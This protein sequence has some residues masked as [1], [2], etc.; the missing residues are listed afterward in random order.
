MPNS[1][2]PFGWQL[3]WRP[4]WWSVNCTKTKLVYSSTFRA[5]GTNTHTHTHTHKSHTQELDNHRAMQQLLE[6][7]AS[8]V[9]LERS[10]FVF[11]EWRCSFLWA[12]HNPVPRVQLGLAEILWSCSSVAVSSSLGV[13]SP[14]FTQ[15]AKCIHRILLSS[16]ACLALSFFFST[17]RFSEIWY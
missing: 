2:W 14:L 7:S 9:S 3:C 5:N 17:A 13:H 11:S 15:Q 6:I 4:G 10:C 16:M 12:Q 8:S 1:L